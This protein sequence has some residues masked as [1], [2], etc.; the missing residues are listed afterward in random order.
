MFGSFCDRESKKLGLGTS[1]LLR[2]TLFN[3]R[4]V[5]FKV[6]VLIHCRASCR[7]LVAS[8]LENCFQL[9][10]AKTQKI[11][12]RFEVLGNVSSCLEAL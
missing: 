6:R 11:K 3:F 8:S 12:C 7:G 2:V 4:S 1:R 10:D 9:N 5:S